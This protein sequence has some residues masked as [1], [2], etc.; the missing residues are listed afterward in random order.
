M[1]VS[2]AALK[3]VTAREEFPTFSTAEVT[4][5]RLEGTRYKTQEEVLRK[6]QEK[7]K[8]KAILIERKPLR[9]SLKGYWKQG[10][11]LMKKRPVDNKRKGKNFS[12]RTTTKRKK[13][14]FLE[15][16]QEKRQ[17]LEEDADKDGTKRFL[18]IVPR[19]EAPIEIESLST[20]GDGS[21]K[22]YKILSEMLQDFDRMDVEQLFRLVKERYS[23]SAPE[24]FDLMLKDH[25]QPCLSLNKDE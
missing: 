3:K 14:L 22:N 15:K 1:R 11:V 8:G 18:D 9:R 4:I 12:H 10:T 17:K 25:L 23:S 24:G 6:D 7:T 2:T 16:L 5:I 13:S 21:S 19:E 20:K